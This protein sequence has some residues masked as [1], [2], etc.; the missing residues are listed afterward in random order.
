MLMGLASIDKVGLSIHPSIYPSIHPSIYCIHCTYLMCAKQDLK[1]PLQNFVNWEICM[2]RIRIQG[3]MP[4]CGIPDIKFHFWYK[5]IPFTNWWSFCYCLTVES[6]ITGG[7][8]SSE[9]SIINPH[10]ITFLQYINL[11][12]GITCTY[13]F[14]VRTIYYYHFTILWLGNR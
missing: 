5:S 7:L 2:T 12:N 1:D 6:L 10:G 9:V 4:C 11:W 13:R 8:R 3:T 14:K